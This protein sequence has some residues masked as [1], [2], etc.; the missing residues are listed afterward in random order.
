MNVDDYKTKTPLILPFKG[1]WIV[2]NGGR[3]AS[4]NSHR[5]PDDTGPR[6]QRFAYDFIK[7][8][9]GDGKNLEDY[10]AF[11]SEVIAPAGGIISQVIN[12]SKDIPIG[13]SDWVVICGNMVVIDHE[14]EEWS[15]LAHL[16]HNSIKVKVGDKVKQ[17]DLLGLCGNTGN[18]T[19]PH[20]HY[21]LQNDSIMYRATGLPAQFKRIKV[22]GVLRENVELEGNQK[23]SNF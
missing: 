15:V 23:I 19:E 21:H 16:K 5:N 14:N 8:H 3:D 2:G 17:G 4:G 13:E 18:T 11:G 10:E 6:N 1:A 7:D 12:G 20:M 22:N 9:K